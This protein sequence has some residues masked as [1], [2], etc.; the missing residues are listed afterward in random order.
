MLEREASNGSRPCMFGCDAADAGL[1]NVVY[2]SAA[3][4][5]CEKGQQWQ[6]SLPISA[7]EKGQQGQH[8]LG[9]YAS[10]LPNVVP[11]VPPSVLVRRAGNG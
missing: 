11:A 7:C 9:L 10:V 6:R 4:S 5:A 2:C 1:P 3:V 8:A